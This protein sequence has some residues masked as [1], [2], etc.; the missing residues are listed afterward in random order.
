[1]EHRRFRILIATVAVALCVLGVSPSVGFASADYFGDGDGHHGSKAVTGPETVNAYSKVA[2]DVAVNDTSVEVADGAKFSP[3]DLIMLWQVNGF[4]TPL[5]GEQS[6]IDLAGQAVG[7]FEL[8]RVA[9]VIGDVLVLHGA[10]KNTFTAA[11]SQVVFIP[12]YSSVSIDAAGEIQAADWDPATGEGGIVAFLA[13]GTVTMDGRVTANGAG[14]VGGTDLGNS[15]TNGCTGLDEP[16]PTGGE[17]GESIAGLDLVSGD[18]PGGTGRGNRANGGG[19]GVCHNSGGGGG[20]HGGLGGL[21]GRTWRDD[22]DPM[23][24][25]TGRD[26]G[27]LGGSPLA[28][29]ALTRLTMGGG[30]GA[31]QQNNNVGGAGSDGG[32]IV[33]V[34]ARRVLGGGSFEANGDDGADATGSANDAAGGAGAGGLIVVRSTGVLT[35]GSAQAVGGDGGSALFDD[36]GTGGG[37]AGGHTLL[38]GTTIGCAT[39]V[40]GGL[41]GV[42]TDLTDPPGVHYGALSGELGDT[43]SVAAALSIDTDGDGLLDV[44]EGEV[45]SDND[46]SPD[47]L[48]VDDDGD[49]IPTTVESAD[50]NG[51]GDPTDANDQDGDLVPDY[52][53]LDSDA[54]GLTDTREAGG[55]DD[56]G[57]GSP[58]GCVDT[59][60]VDGQCDGATLNSPSNTDG[61]FIGG[62]L[63]P[64]YLDTDSDADGID[65]SDEAFDADEDQVGDV[66][67]TSSD[68]DADGLDDAFDGDCFG[69]GNPAGCT[70]VGM[71]MTGGGIPD[72][73]GDGTPNWLQACGDGY[74]TAVPAPESCDDGDGDDSNACDDACR[75]NVGFGPCASATDCAS[76][77][78]L[79]CDQTSSLCQLANGNGPCS[80]AGQDLV[81]ES[82][83]CD[84]SKGTCEACA[85]DEDCSVGQRCEANSC[86]Q[87]TCGDGVLDPGESCDDGDGDDANECANA[88]L[89]NAGHGSCASS[90][91]CVGSA[92]VCDDPASVCRFPLGSGPCTESGE[93]SVCASG[94]CDSDSNSCEMCADDGD[95]ASG[96]R[97][98]TNACVLATCGDGV[99]DSGEA[100]DRGEANDDS[101]QAC[102]IDCLWNVGSDCVDDDECTADA[103]CGDE[104]T[105]TVP[106]PR[107]IDSDGDGI[108]D[109]VEEG[110][111]SLQGGRGVGCHVGLTRQSGSTGVLLLMLA[112][113]LGIRRYR[114]N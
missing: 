21:G 101:P 23:I 26:V 22:A 64:D 93:D 28:Y 43:E 89:F 86:L 51:N 92:L 35:C 108:P 17:K 111:F 13:T 77:T 102:A 61:T 9:A 38:Q 60:P 40:S 57:D 82:G 29:T 12:E 41:P 91:D 78:G 24:P 66:L 104:S 84:P 31:G 5:S 49:G 67:A 20:G 55:I 27:G 107:T 73:D 7:R 10:M 45:D 95:C 25:G 76:G 50:P 54:D 110:D 94:V 114:R 97:C 1:M 68:H 52:L 14:F 18:P 90:D 75:F 34:R 39:D 4:A 44:R 109:V 56:D 106:D 100:C 112:L 74:L 85:D 96:E 69:P 81:C 48:D 83:I 103:T 19:G 105:C 87:R 79:V 70:A 16:S 32:G 58:D 72:D 99:V 53:D 65:D 88:C 36:H 42:Q 33:F 47:F 11:N 62:D 46:N 98:E 37:G 71:P 113:C 63:V 2:A 30:G 59:A 8:A 3:G 15:G 6:E 80:E